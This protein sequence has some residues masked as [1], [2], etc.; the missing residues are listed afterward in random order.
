MLSAQNTARREARS[1]VLHHFPGWWRVIDRYNQHVFARVEENIAD[2][3]NTARAVVDAWINSPEHRANMLG[4][5][6]HIGVG[7]V[8]DGAG[9]IWWTQHFGG[10][11]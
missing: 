4:A 9:R 5:V 6:T 11:A 8:K 2:G 1:G 3:Q 10:A 7:R